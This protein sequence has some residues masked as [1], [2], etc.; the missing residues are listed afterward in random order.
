MA[1]P[2]VHIELNTT[3]LDKA[4]SF[5]G[6]LLNW[7]L[8]DMPMPT[9]AYTMIKVGNGTGGGMMTHPMGGP[10]IWV[11]YI[12]VPDI[13]ASVEKARSL[14]ANIL[15][16]PVEIPMGWFAVALDPTGA[17]FGLWKNK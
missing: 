17:A 9:G 12:D 15:V 16:G 6:Q 8:E 10:S 13:E 11:P 14:G 7:E 1:N 2:F 3:D 5:Y 4:K